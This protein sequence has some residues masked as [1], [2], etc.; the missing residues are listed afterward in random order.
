MI[1][2]RKGDQMTRLELTE[3]VKKAQNGDERA[4]EEI[5]SFTRPHVFNMA[6]SAL[7]NRD[8]AEDIVQDC[9]VTVISKLGEL[10]S[11]ESFEKW[12]NTLAANKIKDYIKKK[13]PDLIGD[14]NFDYIAD[15]AEESTDYI[16]HRKLER[17][18]NS[19]TVSK[20][21]SELSE[22]KRKC[23]EMHYFDEKSVSEIADELNIPE[24]TVKSRLHQG[25]KE[26]GD[27]IKRRST[28]LL[29][30]ILI[31]IMLITCSLSVS[32]SRKVIFD[33]ITKVYDTFIEITVPD[34]QEKYQPISVVYRMTYVPDGFSLV[35]SVDSADLHFETYSR[36]NGSYIT[37]QQYTFLVKD[38]VDGEGT[39][40]Y[41]I[42]VGNRYI[43]VFR[44][45]GM[46]Y[47][48]W[49]D[50]SYMYSITAPPEISD[51]EMIKIVE[52]IVPM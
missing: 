19:E 35:N 49:N 25:R 21:V 10:K 47:F 1:S 45:D 33:F 32:S 38:Y 3:L 50:E 13:K 17:E 26:V 51:E 8:D 11:P 52:G 12:L 15:I 30:T 16:P 40:I 48:K 46:V 34:P 5:Y 41:D 24:N 18:D 14:E 23:I 4:L 44:N 42:E 31:I 28:K 9:Y 22:D 20:I 2:D 6:Y 27:K 29:I 43:K 37:Y 39:I 36:E 7:K